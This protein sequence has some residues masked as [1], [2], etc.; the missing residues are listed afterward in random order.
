MSVLLQMPEGQ[1]WDSRSGMLSKGFNGVKRTES[2]KSSPKKTAL[3]HEV[4]ASVLAVFT[5]IGSLF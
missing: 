5:Y 4:C 1:Q 3:L 2:S